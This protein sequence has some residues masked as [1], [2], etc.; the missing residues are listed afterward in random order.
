MRCDGGGGG[1]RVWEG[2]QFLSVLGQRCLAGGRQ[3][4]KGVVPERDW[5]VW[6]GL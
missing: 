2:G 4:A 3:K 5:L 1:G 6:G